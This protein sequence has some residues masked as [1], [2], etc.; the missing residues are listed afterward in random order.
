MTS[1]AGL[2]KEPTARVVLIA[3]D[4]VSLWIC[5]A[6]LFLFQLLCDLK[7]ALTIRFA[8]GCKIGSAQLIM[9]IGS[10]RLELQRNLQ[11]VYCSFDVTQRQ[12]SLA[13]F[14]V[15]VG[16]IGFA[17]NYFP[18]QLNAAIGFLIRQEDKTEM[19]F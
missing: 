10:I 14:I 16:I 2:Q 12:Q 15:R 13:E 3:T 4:H 7:L 1:T 11:L 5:P 8:P 9:D 17:G 18:H 19:I 6:P